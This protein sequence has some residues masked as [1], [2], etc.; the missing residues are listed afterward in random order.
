VNENGVIKYS[1][2]EYMEIENELLNSKPVETTAEPIQEEL[3]ITMKKTES[4]KQKSRLTSL[5]RSRKFRPWKC[6]SKKALNS[7]PTKEDAN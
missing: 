6:L 1:L 2:E 7:A 3:N 4:Q 5:P